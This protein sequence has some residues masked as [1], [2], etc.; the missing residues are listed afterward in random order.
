MAVRAN[1]SIADAALVVNCIIFA[2]DFN[3]NE[4]RAFEDA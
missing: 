2:N 3:G 4:L 1:I